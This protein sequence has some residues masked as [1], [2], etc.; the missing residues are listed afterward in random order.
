[1]QNAS[2]GGRHATIKKESAGGSEIEVV[3]V[4]GGDLEERAGSSKMQSIPVLSESISK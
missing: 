3:R 2:T 4:G 1:M